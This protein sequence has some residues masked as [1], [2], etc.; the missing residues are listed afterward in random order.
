MYYKSVIELS[1]EI[2]GI[3]KEEL[4]RKA[5]AA[6]GKVEELGAF[7]SSLIFLMKNLFMSLIIPPSPVSP[8]SMTS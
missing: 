5:K 3:K 6:A 2:K 8:V 4:I 1:E 7:S